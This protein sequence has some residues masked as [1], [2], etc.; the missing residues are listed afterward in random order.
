MEFG[1]NS[2]IYARNATI[3]NLTP[4]AMRFGPDT[5]IDIGDSV[6]NGYPIVRDQRPHQGPSGQDQNQQQRTSGH[7]RSDRNESR[8]T[9]SFRSST[10]MTDGTILHA[11]SFTTYGS[12]PHAPR[13]SPFAPPPP[14]PPPNTTSTPSNPQPPPYSHTVPNPPPRS[15]NHTT[16]APEAP[17]PDYRSRAPSPIPERRRHEH[18]EVHER[19]ETHETHEQRRRRERSSNGNPAAAAAAATADIGVRSSTTSAQNNGDGHSTFRPTMTQPSVVEVVQPIP[20]PQPVE[21]RR[22]IPDPQPV[23]R[24]RVIPDTQ[25][26]ERNRAIPN[27]PQVDGTRVTEPQAGRDEPRKEDTHR[28]RTEMLES[29]G[30]AVLAVFLMWWYVGSLICGNQEN[31]TQK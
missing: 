10:V 15:Q 19:H 11:Q 17:P 31:E 5:T 4:N 20:D 27:P 26:V 7:H 8:P 28:N 3:N 22:A 30:I 16:L 1:G 6:V 13:H 18:N 21:R 29:I 25:P 12:R 23:E 24:R 9:S 14:P 2:K